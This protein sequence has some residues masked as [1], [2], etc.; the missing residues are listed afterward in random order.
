M[1]V[2]MGSIGPAGK[3]LMNGLSNLDARTCVHGF[4]D[5][6]TMISA[7]NSCMHHLQEI[8]YIV[9]CVASMDLQP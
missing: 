2:S 1:L 5:V 6:A 8:I 3:K 4:K 9:Y 7:W